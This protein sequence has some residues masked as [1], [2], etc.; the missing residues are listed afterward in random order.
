MHLAFIGMSGIGKSHWAKQLAQHGWLHLDCDAM[1]AQRLGE[2]IDVADDE[3]PVHAVGRWMG[4]PWTPGYAEREAQYLALEREVTSEALDTAAAA[5]TADRHVV[6]DTTGSVIYTGDAPLDRLKSETRVVYFE[7]PDSVRD[8]M[9]ELYL[10]EPKPVLWQGGYEPGVDEDQ[11][12]ALGR[13]YAELLRRRASR[14]AALAAVTIGYHAARS[15][16]FD[17]L[18]ALPR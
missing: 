7:A 1:I 5:Q 13:C 18:E 6:L 15:D 3:D 4:M 9:V 14:Y 17:L 16:G 10:R 2:W 11:S 12:V 8:R